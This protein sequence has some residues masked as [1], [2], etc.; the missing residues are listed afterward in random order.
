M[1]QSF[2]PADVRKAII[3]QQKAQDR[4]KMLLNG[5]LLLLLLAAPFAMYPVFLMKILCFALFAVAFNLLFGFT[6]LLSFGHAA[7]LAT[8]GYTTGYLLSNY[9]G[10]TTEVGIIA[11][12]LVATALG[13]AFALLSI[14]RQGIYFAMVTLALAQ[15]VYFFFVQSEFTGGEDGMHGIPRGHLFGLIDLSKNLNMYYFVLAVFIGCYLLVQRI[16]SSPYGQ[17]LKAIKQ[18][19]PRAVS[20]GYNVDRYKVLAFVIS[21]ALAGL[22]GS[23]KSV[24]FQLASLN[25]AHWHMSG[26][27]ILMTL[28]GGMG[29]LLGPVV[30]ATFVVNIEYQLSQGPLRDWVNPILGGIF[31]LTVLAFRS[32]IVGEIQKFLRKNL[33]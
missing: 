3:D 9:S 20:L 12:T 30:G 4:R 17:V 13:L 6:G 25:D 15:L 14:R 2:N 32:G 23:M 29:T 16:V 18:N 27:V 22:A 26:E 7:F 1:S 33:G 10:L 8:G 19:E 28:V 21:A 31:V 11:G 24:V 5:V